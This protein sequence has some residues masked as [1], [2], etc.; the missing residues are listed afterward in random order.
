MTETKER[1]ETNV[2]LLLLF[3]NSLGILTDIFQFG[4]S[5]TIAVIIVVIIED[6]FVFLPF[7]R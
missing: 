1:F 7:G 6:I 5:V 3:S 4:R 2:F